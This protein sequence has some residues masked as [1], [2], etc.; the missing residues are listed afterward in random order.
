MRVPISWLSEYVDL[1]LSPKELRDTLTML[2]LEV[3]EVEKI[4]G[5]TVLDLEITVNRGDALSIVGVARDLS[6][7]LKRKLKIPDIPSI[8]ITSET[9]PKITIAE[10]KLCPRYTGR[11]VENVNVEESPDWLKKRLSLCGIR[12][13]NNIVDITNYVL[14]ELGHPMHAF[15]YERLVG[16]EIV[17]RRAK[18][19]EDMLGLD[20]R[21]Y[22][23]NEDILV[24]ADKEKPIA[25]GGVIGGEETAVSSLTTKVLLEAAYFDPILIRRTSKV[26]DVVTESSY[27]FERMVD[28]EGLIRAQERATELILQLCSDAKAS[29]IYDCYLNSIKEKEIFLRKRMISRILGIEIKDDEIERILSGLGF[30]VEVLKDEFWVKV[31][32][33]RREVEREIDLI[34]EVARVMGYDRIG[35]THPASP[36]IPRFDREHNMIERMREIMV[37]CGMC[38]VIT[39][40][41]V[42][43]EILDALGIEK[44]RAIFLK[45]P[46]TKEATIMTPSLIAN[47]LRVAQTN[48]QRKVKSL[49]IFEIGKVFSRKEQKVCEAWSLAGLMTGGRKKSWAGDGRSWLLHDLLGI[50]ER[51]FTEI[52]AD[53]SFASHKMQLFEYGVKVRSDKREIGIAGSVSDRVISLFEPLDQSF[54]FE[55]NIKEMIPLVKDKRYK[56]IPRYPAIECDLSLIVKKG[57]KSAELEKIMREEA[58]GLIEDLTLYDIYKGKEVPKDRNSLTYS[59][60]YRA[61]DRTLTMDEIEDIQERTLE[62]LNNELGVSLRKK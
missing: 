51:L 17:V 34:E 15:D 54:V 23:L 28:I 42:D 9:A 1:D 7:F 44:K 11:V 29:K 41:F 32:S 10:P 45:S 27:R 60:V 50:I 37:G 4:D 2:G 33:F 21:H 49:S 43:E 25:I 57:I 6:V 13:I 47:L 22:Q 53:C 5:E 19:R 26:L 12:P 30:S 3:S 36:V 40:S 20:E 62:R 48:A 31:P 16:K 59:I 56:E 14:L 35:E 39:T 61:K 24:I 55:L 52:G 58:E 18:R 46:L 8:P 38:E